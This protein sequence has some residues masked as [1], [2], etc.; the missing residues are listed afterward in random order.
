MH[1]GLA[2]SG[3]RGGQ[4]VLVQ[5]DYEYFHYMQRTGHG[6]NKGY[7]DNGWGCAYRSLQSIISWFRL[8]QYTALRNPTHYDIQ[9]RLVD[10]CGQSRD[11]LLGKKMWIGSLELGLFLEHALGV[12]C[13]TASYQSGDDVAADGRRL[14]HHFQTQGTPVMIGGGQLAFTLL[15]VH[16]DPASG[17]I[18]YLIMDP[19]YVGPDDL[20][21]IQ[22]KWVGWKSGDSLTHLNTKL[23]RKDTF[24][25]FCL[26]MR[27]SDV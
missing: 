27:P 20:S 1:E 10:H 14:A 2:P 16:W 4:P 6:T 19:H 13:R 26:P 24:Y 22:P 3:L 7:D 23:F 11:E 15:G 17:D 12:E 8:Q 18:R 25:S 9:K 21:Q 5:G